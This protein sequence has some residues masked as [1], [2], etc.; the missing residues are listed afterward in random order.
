MNQDQAKRDNKHKVDL[1]FLPSAA[2]IE[3]ARVWAFG[4][5]KY[6]RDNWKTLWG[7]STV[8]VVMA[9][10]LRHA[11]KILDGENVDKESGCLHAAHIRCNAA[12]LIEYLAQT[13]QP[14]LQEVKDD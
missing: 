10:L 4:A 2:C 7:D 8:E 9:S 11:F 14:H 13:A 1:T 6:D 12:M 5:L 3:E